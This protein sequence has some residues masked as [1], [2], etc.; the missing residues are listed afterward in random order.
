MPPYSIS[1]ARLNAAAYLLTAAALC[2]V[3]GL[4]LL[5]TLFAGLLVY[6]LVTA[7]A[8]TLQRHVPGVHAHWLVVAL[9]AILVV[10]F[11]TL[12]IAAGV[13]F[14]T[15]KNGNPSAFFERLTP[16]I[17]RAHAQLPQ[18]IVDR[19]PDDSADMRTAVMDWLGEH[20]AQVQVA[21][22]QAV[23]V[24]VQ[25]IIGIVLGVLLA[26]HGAH[27]RPP[28]GP[29]SVALNARAAHLV[30]A[31]RD[32]VFAQI[33]I[34]ALNTLLT[35]GFLLIGLPL[36]GVTLP[37][38]KT[39]VVLTFVVGL[40]PV[41]GNLISNTLI[42]VV[43]LSHSLFVAIAALAFLVVIHK[44]EYFLSA[45][46]LGMRIQAFAWE[47]LIAMLVMETLFG[48]AGLIAAPIYYAY[49]K[50]E[51]REAGLITAETVAR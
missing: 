18:F 48:T 22:K 5:P 49:V 26:L 38:A 32:V 15:S 46:L 1:I 37:L 16:L 24:V 7:L 17:E 47:L 42:F 35:G 3:L 39:L 29:L 12:A 25:L 13:D 28:G 33:K 14:L 2:F 30:H 21:G 8:A 4:H 41:I 51:L 19:L 9:L 27:D 44:L 34:S 40:L 31:F 45:R 43:A 50:R 6:S 10:G 20:T 23:R 36:F 11:F